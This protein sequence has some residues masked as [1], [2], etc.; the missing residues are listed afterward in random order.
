[1]LIRSFLRKTPTIA[2][3]PEF[4][5]ALNEPDV[6]RQHYGLIGIRNILTFNN[7]KHYKHVQDVIDAGLVPRMMKCV[8]QE[9]C[10][11]LQLEAIR[12]LC[13]VADGTKVQCQTIVDEGAIPLVSKLLLSRNI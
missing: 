11:Q 1:M 7:C 9:E 2:D 3:L 4:A 8:K 6:V 5:K 10:L 12:A 13:I